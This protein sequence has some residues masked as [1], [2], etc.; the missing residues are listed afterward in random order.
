MTPLAL[1]HDT[2]A[3][4][5][6]DCVTACGGNKLVGTKLWPEMDPVAAGRHLADCLN[7]AKREKLSPE[8][9]VLVLRLAR[10]RGC[11]IGMGYITQQLG[12]AEPQPVEPED[13]R[14]KLQREFIESTKHLARLA[15]HIEALERPGRGRAA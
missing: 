1:F 8:Q 10:E 6:R 5:L 2:L 13:E 7:D 12:Y 14:A 3:D 9:L 15:Q 11:H 4:A